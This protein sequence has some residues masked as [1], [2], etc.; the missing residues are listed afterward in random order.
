MKT[1]YDNEEE[2]MEKFMKYFYFYFSRDFSYQAVSRSSETNEFN[3]N[4]KY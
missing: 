2:E 4:I 3:N 1:N